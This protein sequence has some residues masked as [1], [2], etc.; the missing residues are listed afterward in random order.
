MPSL[1]HIVLTVLFSFTHIEKLEVKLKVTQPG[2]ASPQAVHAHCGK[3]WTRITLRCMQHVLN[4]IF[5]IS[6]HDFDVLVVDSAPEGDVY[7]YI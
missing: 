5:L 3:G 2:M 7:I 1:Q 4:S 6:T